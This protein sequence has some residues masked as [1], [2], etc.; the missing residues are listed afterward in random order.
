MSIGLSGNATFTQSGGTNTVGNT[1]TLA[2]DTSS[3]AA[4]NLSGGSLSINGGSLDNIG[5]FLGQV[6]TGVF[7]QN[8]GSLSVANNEAIG[9]GGGTGTFRRRR[10]PCG[11]RQPLP[12]L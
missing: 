8:G 7:T 10:Q 5:A 1:F 11:G 4:Y 2:A 12:G 3:S 6:G 9:Q